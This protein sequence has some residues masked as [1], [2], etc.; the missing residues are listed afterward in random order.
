ME[1]GVWA[2]EMS[3]CGLGVC[4]WGNGQIKCCQSAVWEY[5]NG[6]GGGGVWVSEMLPDCGLGIQV[7]ANGMLS[8][9]GLGVWEWVYGA[10]EMSE[11]SLEWDG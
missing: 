5:G 6:G 8:E 2:S 11:C 10:S 9:C 7:W 3:E 1:M 4:E